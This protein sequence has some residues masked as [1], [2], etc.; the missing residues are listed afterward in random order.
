M[1]QLG[2]IRPRA[3]C[4]DGQALKRVVG[5]ALARGIDPHV[6]QL[7]EDS[8]PCGVHRMIRPIC[9]TMLAILVCSVCGCKDESTQDQSSMESSDVATRCVRDHIGIDLPETATGVHCHV[10]S[11]MIKWVF[12]RFSLPNEVV[13]DV[14]QRPLMRRL[15]SF[16]QDA[17]VAQELNVNASEIPWW[18]IAADA[19]RVSRASWTKS[20]LGGGSNL[21]SAE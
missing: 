5:R 7:Q 14:L 9:M 2:S 20:G 4:T 19:A 11:L 21:C 10:E 8:N 3:A 12:V 16:Q 1:M 15:P 6:C 13:A 17:T 18:N